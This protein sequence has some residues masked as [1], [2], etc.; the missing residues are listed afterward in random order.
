MPVWFRPMELERDSARVIAYAR[1]L[2]AISFGGTRFADE[3]GDDGSAYIAWVREKQ[4]LSRANA[5]LALLD[6]EPAGMVLLGPW[7]HHPGTGYVYHFYLEPG[8]RGR[9]LGPELDRYAVSTLRRQGFEVARL[10]VAGTNAR[11]LRAYTRQGW[12]H[13][14]AR[15]DQPG[16]L[17]MEKR[18]GEPRS[19]G[20]RLISPQAARPTGNQPAT[21]LSLN[22]LNGIVGERRSSQK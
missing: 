6:G 15:P 4:A 11:A 7:L 10:S 14:G 9:G 18:L 3:F 13:A 20:T 17:Y 1:D 8:A 21:T 5:A 22:S 12:A 19:A 2:F 16:I